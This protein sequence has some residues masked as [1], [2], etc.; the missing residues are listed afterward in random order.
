MPLEALLTTLLGPAFLPARVEHV[1]FRRPKKEV[2]GRHA[3][4]LITPMEHHEPIW[5]WSMMDNPRAPM[6]SDRFPPRGRQL[7]VSLAIDAP[8]PDPASRHRLRLYALPEIRLKI[9]PTQPA[10]P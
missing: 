4:W 7:T 3:P 6:R 8:S 1:V 9:H 2:I 10:A 5:Y